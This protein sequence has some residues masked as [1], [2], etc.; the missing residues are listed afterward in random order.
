MFICHVCC[1]V[2]LLQVTNAITRQKK[3]DIVKVL[4]GKL[5]DSVIVFGLRVKGLSVSDTQ[6]HGIH[7]S[8]ISHVGSNGGGYD[9]GSSCGVA[10][11]TT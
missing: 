8:S 2:V 6:L 3:E 10:A 5:D 1:G 11:T 4:E 9:V 7:S